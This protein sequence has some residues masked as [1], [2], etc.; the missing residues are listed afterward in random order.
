MNSFLFFITSVFLMALTVN[1]LT[2]QHQ[3]VTIPEQKLDSFIDKA[4]SHKVY[5][6]FN[7]NSYRAGE[8]MWF[9]TYLLNSVTHIPD[10]SKTNVYV[11]LIDSEGVIMERR[12]LM[13]QDGVAEGDISLPLTLP[14]GN[15]CLR[16]YTDWMRNF[17]EEFYFKRYFYIGN[18]Q[19]EDMIPRSDARSNRRFNRNLGQ[20]A[21]DHDIAFF[22]EGGNMVN[23]VNNRVAF[24]AVDGLGRGL[25]G[26]GVIM[27]EQGNELLNFSTIHAGMGSFDLTPENGISYRAMVSFNG[28]RPQSFDLPKAVNEGIALRT[29]RE[30]EKIIL[31]LS[32][33]TSPGEPAYR[34]EV[35]VIAHTRGDVKY[36]ENIKFTDKEAVAVMPEELF[37]TGITVITV[38]SRDYMP[39]A[40]RLVFINKD[41]N[42]IITPRIF[43][44]EH[45][46]QDFLGI[47]MEITDA[48]GRPVDGN[49]SLSILDGAFSPP[50][51]GTNIL[52]NILLSSDLD[53]IIENPQFYFDTEK[54]M[55]KEM[56]HLMM[57]HGWRRFNWESV[58]AEE[59]PEIRYQPSAG[60]AIRGRVTDPAKDEPVNNH[61]IRM[62]VMGEKEDIYTTRTD[63]RGYFVFDDL[64]YHDAFRVEVGS[65]RLAGDYPPSIE[66]LTG[67]IKGYEYTPNIYTKE[68]RITRRGRDWSHVKEAGKSPYEVAPETGRSPQS[69]G[70]A[71]QTIYIDRDKVTQRSVYDLLIAR[72]QGLQV[73]GNTLM[74]RGPASINLSSEPM[75]MLDGV[76]TGKDVVLSMSPR[77][78]ERIEIFKGPSASIFGVR[79]ASGVIIAYQRMAGDQGFEDSKEY[80]VVG[81][82]SPREFYSD[83]LSSPDTG[84]DESGGRSVH[85]EPNMTIG[86]NG[87]NTIIIPAPASPSKMKIVV[88]GTGT[89]GG[90]GA[91]IFTIEI[92]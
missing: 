8:V 62:K 71:D 77:E 57:T 75:F 16:A 35:V 34:D 3:S 42:F 91:G 27:D 32:S 37:A 7:K 51:S 22:P 23:G 58:L 19:Y 82:H 38:F 92:R 4:A 11:D 86:Q 66:L 25:D 68:E 18:N 74:F 49:F 15:Y 29:E 47:Q 50:G 64:M 81:Y 61:Q 13:A 48:G 80:L 1:S 89:G 55:E 20:M 87:D 67:D 69:Y 21:E 63:G 10:T 33:G 79:G 40:E 36:S 31:E 72:A 90:I 17:D 24:K 5:L 41:D 45:E 6:H 56:D 30:N 39:L 53:G 59:L 85:W 2:G 60:L 44:T 26:E 43:K 76:Q 65:N 28:S 84:L 52:S 12:V 78:V 88:E 73:Y 9:N 46:G 14:D 70:I 54:D 83:I